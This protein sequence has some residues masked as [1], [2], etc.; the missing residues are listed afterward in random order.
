MKKYILPILT[1]GVLLFA[2][3]NQDASSDAAEVVD[4][5]AT[6]TT[7]K[8]NEVA[9]PVVDAAEAIANATTMSVDRM[10][11]DFGEIPDTEPATTT[12]TITNTGSNPLI[13]SQAKGSCGCTVPTYPKEPIAPGA[14]GT[15]EVSF[16]PKGKQGPQ[17]KTVTLIAN[18]EPAN[19]VMNIKSNVIKTETAE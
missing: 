12:F 11:H 19:T 4:T 6:E 14:T 8:V 10:E 7:E 3:C 13:I 9:Q 18:T 1:A 5:A 2:S 17:N 15:I 16:S